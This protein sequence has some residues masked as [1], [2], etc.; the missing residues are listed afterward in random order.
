MLASGP[1]VNG[2]PLLALLI[3]RIATELPETLNSVLWSGRGKDTLLAMRRHHRG[4][5][6]PER[7]PD[8]HAG[9]FWL[10]RCGP[11]S[12]ESALSAFGSAADHLWGVGGD[13]RADGPARRLWRPGRCFWAGVLSGVI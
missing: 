9:S 4:D 12:G 6:L 8:F 5:G 1:G 2:T 10:R 7:H 3:A 11:S 13:L